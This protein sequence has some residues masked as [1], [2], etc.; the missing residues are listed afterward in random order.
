MN[1]QKPAFREGQKFQQ[2]VIGACGGGRPACLEVQGVVTH[3]YR[4]L[5]RRRGL[6]PADMHLNVPP[7]AGPF[8]N[9]VH[10]DAAMQIQ[11][12]PLIQRMLFVITREDGS[13]DNGD[14]IR[15]QRCQ[16]REAQDTLRGFNKAGGSIRAS[17]ARIL[18]TGTGSPSKAM[19]RATSCGIDSHL[20]RSFSSGVRLRQRV[21]FSFQVMRHR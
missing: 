17:V 9:K 18:S 14:A 20:R 13:L 8:G 16:L 19:L 2:K 15:E 3:Q 12:Q 5:K 10:A 6:Q 7:L 21:M 4:Q 1:R 11:Q